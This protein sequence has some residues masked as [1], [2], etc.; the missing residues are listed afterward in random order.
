MIEPNL[1][2]ARLVG[3]YHA[4]KAA[5]TPEQYQAWLSSLPPRDRLFVICYR[6][7]GEWGNL[8]HGDS[9]PGVIPTGIDFSVF[10]GIMSEAIGRLSNMAQIFAGVGESA[11]QG[12]VDGLTGVVREIDWGALDRASRQL[13]REGFRLQLLNCRIPS[14]LANWLAD[15]WPY[16]LLPSVVADQW[17]WFRFSLGEKILEWWRPSLA[18]HLLMCISSSR[19]TDDK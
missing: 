3:S 2:N 6:E 14:R 11:A 15:R 19:V 5:G 16:A 17:D 9:L 4:Y 1:H 7:R 8:D 12:L 10:S 18:R 13:Y